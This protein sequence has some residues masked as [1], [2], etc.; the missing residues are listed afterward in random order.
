MND[1]IFISIC[2]P[3]Y[4]RPKELNRLLK[5]IDTIH[6][7][8][9]EIVICEDNAPKRVEVRTIVEQFKKE[10]TYN[11]KYIENS[12]NY[13]HGKNM[14][15]CIYHS[16]G[17]YIIYMGDDDM[18]IPENFDKFYDFAFKHRDCGYFLRSYSSIS[19]NHRE[20]FKYFNDDRIFEPGFE[21]YVLFFGKSIAMS[22]YTIKKE[23]TKN[24][25]I[26]DLDKTLLFQVYLMAEVCLKYKS[27]YFNTPIANVVGS[28]TSYFGTSKSEKGYYT[29]GIP[30]NESDYYAASYLE[31]TRYMDNKYGFDSTTLIL[32]DLS[33]YCFY[34]LADLRQYGVKRYNQRATALKS[35]G[36]DCTIYFKVY[37]LSLLF[38]GKMPCIYVI[39]LLKKAKGRRLQL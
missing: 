24:F 23:Y 16:D 27:A 25:M 2:I 9:V 37:Y 38:F 8:E 26:K 32:K 28:D 15:E 22:G 3:S 20:D 19:N 10:T 35:L 5:S 18:F 36:L 29:P 7:D 30:V 31:V 13:G 11:V 21:T 17:E 33:K 12:E 6:K 1:V 34:G 14:R 4:N 39:R